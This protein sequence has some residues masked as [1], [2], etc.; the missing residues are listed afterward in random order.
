MAVCATAGTIAAGSVVTFQKLHCAEISTK[1]LPIGDILGTAAVTFTT[2]VRVLFG[3]CATELEAK[4]SKQSFFAGTGTIEQLR[5]AA[6][7]RLSEPGHVQSNYPPE[8]PWEKLAHLVGATDLEEKRILLDTAGQLGNHQNQSNYP[9]G[10]S[11]ETL[12]FGAALGILTGSGV[13]ALIPTVILPAVGFGTGGITG[14][15]IAAY[16]QSVIGNVIVGSL[17]ASAQS[18]GAVGAISLTTIGGIILIG[19]GTGVV[20]VVAVP[21]VSYHLWKKSG[22]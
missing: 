14:G 2:S 11:W 9:P 1:K 12:G 21:A 17:F 19:G 18:A 13:S 16:I 10:I 22:T 8:M 5:A 4:G 7:E 3:D 15:S 20:A 6:A